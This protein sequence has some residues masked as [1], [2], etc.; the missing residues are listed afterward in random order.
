MT[1][2]KHIVYGIILILF[3]AFVGT[4]ALINGVTRGLPFTIVAF[5][6]GIIFFIFGIIEELS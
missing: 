2:N 5:I 6:I 4:Y 3:N 1:L